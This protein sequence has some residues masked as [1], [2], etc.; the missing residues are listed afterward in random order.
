MPII[1]L[2]TDFGTK[3]HSV[4]AVKGAIYSELDQVN[5][6]DISHDISPFNYTEAAYVIKNAYH[7]FPK[8]SIHII[9][10]DS[11][12]TPENKHL[13]IYLDGHYFICANNG[14]LSL[15]A[16]EIKPDKI[17]EINI[18]N[19]IETNFTVLDVFV[20]VAA[21]ISRGGALEVIG[22]NID[23][24]YQLKN[25]QP[26]VNQ[27][28]D[29]IIGHV[30]YIDNFGNVVSNINKKDFH[31]LRKGR[32]FTIKARSTSFNKI[33]DS[34]SEAINFDIPKE[35]REME[36][37]KLALFNASNYLE[38]AIYKSNPMSVGAAS[39]LFGLKYMDTITV[40]FL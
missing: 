17:V 19:S 40:N 16:S 11:E 29:Q 18:H 30:I 7:N 3:D 12:L 20:N 8:N 31:Y 32:D 33:Y 1:T 4:A 26:I 35:N 9:G 22:R 38:L 28:K 13:A 6:I 37:K 25:I 10:I 15:I 34:Y 36:G 24:I 5:I 39:T 2:T 21:H 14:I 27:N 23:E